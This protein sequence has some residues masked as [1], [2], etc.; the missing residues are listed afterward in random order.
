MARAKLC[1]EKIAI[2]TAGLLNN[3]APV[4]DEHEMPLLSL[5]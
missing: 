5:F 2:A 3:R 1:V 4:V